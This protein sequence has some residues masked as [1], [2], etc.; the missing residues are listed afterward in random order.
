MLEDTPQSCVC[1]TEP[2]PGAALMY[3]LVLIYHEDV[4]SEITAIIKRQMLVARYTKVQDVVGAR[5]DLL[6]DSDYDAPRG[7]NNMLIIV[8]ECEVITA[9]ADS[10]RALREMKGHGLRG[11]ITPVQSVI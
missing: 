9:L 1:N 8:A 6:E 2:A 3:S 7:K 11:Y 10:F 4:E 5:S